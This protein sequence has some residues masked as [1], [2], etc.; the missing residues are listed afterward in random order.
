VSIRRY[1]KLRRK[2]KHIGLPV[3]ANLHPWAKEFIK[4]N[5][6]EQIVAFAYGEII[7]GVPPDARLFCDYDVP[8]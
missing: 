4:R 3:A 7:A 6:P 2:F 1:R 8:F 5:S